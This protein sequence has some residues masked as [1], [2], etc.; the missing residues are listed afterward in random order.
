MFTNL[1]GLPAHPLF[2]HIPVV[3][4]PLAAVG[5]VVIAASGRLRRTFGP[6]VVGVIVL[7]FLGAFFAKESGEV[8]LSASTDKDPV[9]EHAELGDLA[10][11]AVLA[12][13]LATGGLVATDVVQRRRTPTE[14]VGAA[15]AS[16]R[17]VPKPVVTVLAV[18]TVVTSLFAALHITRVGHSG[19]K[20]IWVPIDTEA[21]PQG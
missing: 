13:L 15:V 7:A 16:P 2:V 6:L 11:V 9:A 10:P 20:L 3:L 1:F 8:L 17:A 21:L 5:A 18:L 12:M 19:A 14:S 4:T